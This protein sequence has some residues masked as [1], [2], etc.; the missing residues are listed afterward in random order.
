MR[1]INEITIAVKDNDPVTEEEM[2]LCIV[3]MASI[4]YF[5]RSQLQDLIDAIRQK[6]PQ[7]LLEMKAEFAWGTIEHMF[8]AGNKP[9]NKW[10]G[11]GDIPG[12]PE[13]KAR[14]AMAKNIFK[15]AT[16]LDL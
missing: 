3:S 11:P 15:K 9:P 13:N 12:T 7:K 16:G 6:K 4:E 1:T 5:F 14:V 2:R 10:L 8:A